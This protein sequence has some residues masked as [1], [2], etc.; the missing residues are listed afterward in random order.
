MESKANKLKDKVIFG[1]YKILNL[2]SKGTFGTV[3]LAK[4]I[5]TQKL[6]AVKTENKYCKQPILETEAYILYNLKGLGIPSVI[7]YGFFG[8]YNVLVQNLLG[9]SLE[10]IWIEHRKK[11]D[12]KD[13]C[14][15]AIQTLDRIEFVHSKD[16]IHRDIKP[17][18]FLVGNPD[19]FLIYL[20][21]YGNARK[22]RSS[23]TGKHIKNIKTKRIFGTT[24][25]L[26][27]NVLKGNE[28]SRKDDLESLG[29]MYIYL[30]KGSL[31]WSNIKY[32]KVEEMLNLTSKLKQNTS[33]EELCKGLPQ[34]ML[35]YM[36]YVRELK[37]YQKPNYI[38]LRKLFLLILSKLGLRNDN[39][40]SWVKDK[41]I[42]Q[43]S[44]NKNR[45]RSNPQI[46]L[47]KKIIESHSKKL[48]KNLGSYDNKKNT[49]S[50]NNENQNQNQNQLKIISKNNFLLSNF[51]QEAINPK[52]MNVTENKNENIK[53][54]NNY[55]E[56]NDNK[57]SYNAKEKINVN[58]I[59]SS[60][61]ENTEYKSKI[62]NIRLKNNNNIKNKVINSPII[63]LN[64][65]KSN[66]VNIY[67]KMAIKV[68]DQLNTIKSDKKFNRY[69]SKYIPYNDLDFKNNDNYAKSEIL[70]NISQP[71]NKISLKNVYPK[72]KEIKRFI[73]VNNNT[74]KRYNSPISKY[75]YSSRTKDNSYS[76]NKTY[77]DSAK[78]INPRYFKFL[79]KNENTLAN[80]SSFN[81]KT[82][83]MKKFN[84]NTIRMN[85]KKNIH[86]VENI[87]K[88]KN[89]NFNT[90]I[91]QNKKMIYTN[92][93]KKR[94][95]FVNDNNINSDY[96]SMNFNGNNN[97]I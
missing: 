78:F 74:A 37:F 86:D 8:N 2:I 49:N 23:R 42:A 47:M 76:I 9:K 95:L 58:S 16:Y 20:I 25:F 53:K 79:Y 81:K 24:L 84:N 59:K 54:L 1:K 83:I 6:F 22:Y 29:Y 12:L 96:R 90:N 77:S 21:D 48:I 19:N 75:I 46:R 89:F 61:N 11:L 55:I 88:Y 57:K 80:S 97:G 7:S 10:R 34:E 17:A 87:N 4:N 91:K 70:Y 33:L 63:I 72:N 67:K 14:M 3:Y 32:K 51:S 31:P 13:I 18:N 52:K 62:K 94:N 50:I 44:Q 15:I 64:I 73:N 28:Q 27:I 35:L 38:L 56:G 40:F 69:Y 85:Q 43:N 66:P 39:I 68:N 60:K 36:K 71:K 41:T 5:E 92:L 45:S 30:S 93:C 65:N 26:S 82:E